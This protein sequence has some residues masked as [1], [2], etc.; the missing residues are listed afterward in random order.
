MPNALAQATSPYLLQHAEQPVHWQPWGPAAL[1]E[2]AQRN[3]PILLSIGYAACHWCHVMAHESFDDADTAALMNEGFVCIKVDREQR[4]DLDQLYQ[5][6]HLLLAKR[7]GGWP[8]TVFLS[9]GGV[10]FHSGT[11]YPAVASHGRPAFTAVLHSVR[12][13]WAGQREAIATQDAAVLAA[14]ARREPAAAATGEL[15][16]RQ[17]AALAGSV[18]QAARQVLAEAFDA[19]H[20]GFGQAPKFPHPTDLAWLLERG[21][22]EGDAAARD[23]ALQTLRA[24]VHGGLYDQLAGGFFRYSTDAQWRLP[25]FEKMLNDNGLLLA[26]CADAVAL[27][28]EPAF[29]RAVE[30]TVDWLLSDMA[31]PGGGF[32]S[33]LDADAPDGQE[34]GHYLWTA[35]ELREALTPLEWDVAT[36]HWNLLATPDVDGRLWHLRVERDSAALAATFRQPRSALEQVISGARGKLLALRQKRPAPGR[37]AQCLSAWNALAASGLL[38]AAAVARRP[39]WVVAARAALTHI[40]TARW[41]VVPDDGEGDNAGRPRLWSAALAGPGAAPALPPLP[42]LLDDHALLLEAVLALLQA[43]FR[44]DEL[45]WA[46]G[47]AEALLA[48]FEDAQG[49]GFWLTAHDHEALVHRH[50]PLADTALPSGNGSAILGLLR[51][52]Q[53]LGEPRYLQAARRALAALAPTLAQQPGISSKL[54]QAALE[55]QHPP[56]TV[57]LRG[58]QA[59]AW[60]DDL[61]ARPLPHTLVLALPA[62]LGVAQG[63][64]AVLAHAEPPAGHTQ[65]WVCA[66]TECQPPVD[67]LAALQQALGL[68]SVAQPA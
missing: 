18:Q 55:M 3:V 12:E 23:M 52:G 63:L 44:L 50:K 14:L 36:A 38:R 35:A 39:D 10:P 19:V 48:H 5:S 29:G 68:A 2:A 7:G 26:L 22:A 45:R 13:A 37:D 34:G 53:L 40:R 65:A 58:P 42:A 32:A 49:G 28:G 21:I 20:G 56:T 61:L 9:P 59:A 24:M 43:D 16:E 1:A 30:Q 41:H 6:T 62:G 47:L 51:L 11:Y 60:R 67:S 15:A 54:L 46:Q 33:A 8:L 57:L 25:H 66:G 4:P 31:L 27:T 64:P 17:R